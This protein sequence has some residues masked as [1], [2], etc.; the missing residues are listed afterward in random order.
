MLTK[1]ARPLISTGFLPLTL[2]LR[3]L[4]ISSIFHQ[5]A[6]ASKGNANVKSTKSGRDISRKNQPSTFLI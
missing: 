5:S 4:S 6:A 1:V 2:T 3:P